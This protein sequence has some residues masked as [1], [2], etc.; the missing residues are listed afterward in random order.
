LEDLTPMFRQYHR[1][2]EE[3]RDAILMFRMGDFYEMFFEDAL[4]ASRALEITLTARGKGTPHAAPMCGVPYHAV[5]SYVARL[6]R[7]GHKVAICE[8]TSDPG[9]SKGL[10]Q[11]EV[12]RVVTPGTYADPEQVASGEHNFLASLY[13][14]REG[15]GAAYLDLSTGDL[16]VSEI[17]GERS[18]EDL[19]D[20][21]ELFAPRE[22][23]LPEGTQT[24]VPI[25][26]EH[27]TRAVVNPVA[28]WAFSLDTAERA[29]RELTGTA[30]LAGFGLEDRPLA[31]AA[32]G[33]AVHYLQQTQRSDLRHLHRVSF[34]ERT[35]RLVLD[36]TTRRNL[37]ITAT[38][39]DNRREGSLLGTLDL[40]RTPMGS[41]A[42]REVLLRPFARVEQVEP[43]LDGVEA[44]VRAAP[45]REKIRG[46]LQGVRDVE[47]LL[48][49][50]TLRT[51]T[52][53]DYLA[54]RDS[55]AVLPSLR[56]RIEEMGASGVLAGLR[57]RIDPLEDV[58]SLLAAGIAEEPP[59]LT[60]EGGY[61]R[62]GF[63]PELDSLR[64]IRGEGRGFLA[65]LESRER[66]RT[67]IASLKVRYNK[68][69]GY[70]LE[71]SRA[72]LK[73]VPPEYER[74]QTLVGAERFITPELKEFEE[75]VVTAQ[76]RIEG[77]EAALLERIRER[78]AAEAVRIKTTAQAIAE[79]DLL[80]ALAE[81]AA[82]YGY[83]RPVL[84]PD[85]PIRIRD[86]RHPVVER[87]RSDQ[88]FIPNDTDLGS[89]E[90]QI[91]ILTGPNM[92]G[93]STYLRQVAL[94]V[95]LAQAGSFVPAREA[96]IGMADRIF[97]RVGASDNLVR[98]Q[99]TFLIEMQETANILHHASPRSLVLLDEIGRGTAT[100]DGLSLAWA[101]AE[102]LHED[103]RVGA[104]TLF[105]T[106]YHELTELALTLPRV[107]NCHIA[108]REW[109][110]EI[111]FLYKVQEGSADRSY[112]IQVAR[113]AGIPAPVIER[114]REIL[115]NLEMNELNR[116]G[117]PKLAG[118]KSRRVGDPVQFGLFGEAPDPVRE[119]LR[120]VDVE[121]MTPLEALGLLADLKRKAGD[122]RS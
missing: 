91:L 25:P 116:E 29:L 97:C 39:F 88:R 62:D 48:S 110:E 99:S 82:R 12:V 11:R 95:L 58:A 122:P 111:R 55:I 3:H 50:V 16:T 49:R 53:R 85:G 61:I 18:W 106:H 66:E 24:A 89:A 37:E 13:P 113:L 98:G 93:K 86:G 94:I 103:P 9:R 27:R 36:A 114:A 90:R 63:D 46:I 119:A 64:S 117:V 104:R 21:V 45:A 115:H 71:I 44:L 2:K 7:Q 76:E 51:A 77:L 101:V 38:L 69:F 120:V 105:A 87:L 79:V 22:I 67:G 6:V 100:F 60:R 15:V 72:N 52:P 32:A 107:R 81:A 31:V 26:P 96:E 112:G 30:T 19:W 65:S 41:R 56:R 70:Y 47:R 34:Y 8:Q 33:G 108:V 43:R 14:A 118:E 10:V 54:L 73:H 1:L 20:Q 4:L 92:G 40:T 35:D 23:L 121:R 59:A 17:R 80:A 28:E 84:R 102:F 57:E 78:V 5:D 74:K 83:V 75:R 68:V 42:L 109:N